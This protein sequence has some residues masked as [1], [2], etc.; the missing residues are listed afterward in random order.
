MRHGLSVRADSLYCP[1]SLSLDAYGNCLNDCWHCYLRRL[2]YVWGDA[3]NPTDPETLAQKLHN[4]LRNPKPKSCLAYA[5]KR[6]T[7]IRFGNKADPFQPVEAEHRTSKEILDILLEQDWSYVLQTMCTGLMMDYEEIIVKS[8]DLVTVQPII[9]PG[10]E[11]DW[12]I[13]ERKRTT[14]VE[15][16]FAHIRKL[17]KQGV[18]TAVY[19]E[20][21]IPGFHT[22]EM[23]D[24]MMKRLKANKIKNYNTY[25]L[26]LNDFVAKRLLAIDLDIEKIWTLNQDE[27]WKH[28]QRDLCDIADKHNI[29]LGCP[30]F[31]NVRRDRVNETN[32]C[33]GIDVQNPT[34]YNTHTWR[35]LLIDG[36][37]VDEIIEKTWDGVGNHEDGQKILT[38]KAKDMYTMADAGLISNKSEGG[39]LF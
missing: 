39:L 29:I 14:P 26:H 2:N 30:D 25:N 13:L 16:R 36:K 38:G 17:K 8:K 15:E 4:G 33:C 28:I 21:F 23:F 12:E 5:L 24:D 22:L 9:S 7:T 1:L 10:A 3:L 37:S 27:H 34:T 32:T 18:R 35:N 6:K 31:V 11:L 20:P 19:G